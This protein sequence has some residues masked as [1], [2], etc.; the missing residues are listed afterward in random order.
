M[1]RYGNDFSGAG[2]KLEVAYRRD[3][4]SKKIEEALRLGVIECERTGNVYRY[5]INLIPRGWTN[6]R[7]KGYKNKYKNGPKKGLFVRGKELFDYLAEQN[8]EVTETCR[9][10]IYLRDSK[11]FDQNGFDFTKIIQVENWPQERIDKEHKSYMMRIMRKSTGLYQ[12]LEDTLFKLQPVEY[13]LELKEIEILK[14]AK[15][16]KFFDV[17]MSGLVNSDE[18]GLEWTAIVDDSGEKERLTKFSRIMLRGLDDIDRKLVMDKLKLYYVYQQ[19]D[20]TREEHRLTDEELDKIQTKLNK[21]VSEEAQEELLETSTASLKEEMAIYK[22]K[23][24]EEDDPLDAIMEAY[25]LEEYQI[26]EIQPVIDFYE[27]LEE[28]LEEQ[29]DMF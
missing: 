26:D 3:V 8:R 9:R 27:T 29:D 2:N 13:E 12:D 5:Y 10:Q 22:E 6:F 21:R 7:V 15:Y 11:F 20:E 17:Y 25:G 4:F 1:T 28:V 18:N 23:Y 14:R 19:Y 24:G 16:R